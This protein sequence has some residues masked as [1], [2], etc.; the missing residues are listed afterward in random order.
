[1]NKILTILAC[2]FLGSLAAYAVP[3]KPGLRTITQPDG[4][5]IQ[6]EL[7]GDEYCSFYVGAD[8]KPMQFD[9][10]GYLRYVVA[11]ADG[12]VALTTEASAVDTEAAFSVLR[13]MARSERV[14]MN[15][16]DPSVAAAAVA[17]N[18]KAAA[19]GETLPQKGLGLMG[20]QNFPTLGNIKSVVIL[21]SYKDVDFSVSNP[22]DFYT[23]ML[24]QEGFSDYDGC[25]SARDFFVENSHS[26]FV[27]SFDVYGPVK[28]KYNRSYYGAQSGS[29]HDVN[30]SAM[31][32]EGCAA[33]DATVD[34]SQYD[35]DGDGV[36]DNIYVIYA[37]QGQASFGGPDTVWPHSSTIYNGPMHDGVR[38]GRYA[39]SNEWEDVRPDGIGTFVHEFSHVMGLPD[40]YETTYST[41]SITPGEW[42]AMDQGP[43]NDGGR[44]PPYYSSYERNALGWIDLTLIDGPVNVDLPHLGA[45]NEAC[46]IPTLRTNEFFLLENRQKA[47]WDE[48]LPGNG[49]LVW[50]VDYDETIYNQN[51]VNNDPN[52]QY[53]DIVEC[54]GETGA[55][56]GYAFPGTGFI[57]KRKIT[58]DTTPNLTPWVGPVINY[59]ITDI[60]IRPYSDETSH[61]TFKVNGGVASVAVPVATE[62][63]AAS[64]TGFTANWQPVEGAQKYLLTVYTAQGNGESKTET[65]NFGGETDKSVVLPDGW[66]FT[67]AT[68]DVYTAASFCGESKPSIKFNSNGIS[69]TS[70]MY[71]GEVRSVSFFMRAANVKE[72]GVL[73]I[74][75]RTDESADWETID[76]LDNVKDYNLSGEN[77]TAEFPEAGVRQIR[78][79]FYTTSG[80]LALDDVKVN[81]SGT[82]NAILEGYDSKDVADATSHAVELTLSGL[83]KYSYTVKAVDENGLVT[84]ASNSIQVDLSNFS[85]VAN[86]D[87]GSD[88]NLTVAGR[89]AVYRGTAGA[90]VTAVNVAGA[91]VASA[92]ADADGYATLQLPEA[93]FYIISTPE[94][95]RKALVK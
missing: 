41:G 55:P 79:T 53:V 82:Y 25:G 9:A 84:K 12:S 54:N 19:E 75:G 11:G 40:L 88:W 32:I 68:N 44:R 51:F 70:P 6:A 66:N 10:D 74:E 94:G 14:R 81:I 7:R 42:S 36:I 64:A 27:P 61:L 67:G 59:E 2:V 57:K 92:V 28:L 34:F 31:V 48:G 73:L 65:L 89:T 71:M 26:Q 58:P 46:I 45:S 85:G 91:V 4:T 3:A 80:K 22:L 72:H 93:G 87:S 50:H 15:A 8:G 20:R 56:S 43:Y 52:H 33:L 90:A 35:L 60:Y 1:M 62:A 95:T 29:R 47:G 21:V 76:K 86:I 5:T 23:R 39:T 24:N 37:G 18:V 83:N 38:I 69:L 63:T 49:L 13:N 77:F 17:R 16:V 78:F 30:A